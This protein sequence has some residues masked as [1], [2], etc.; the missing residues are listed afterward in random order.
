MFEIIII[1]INNTKK[2]KVMMVLMYFFPDRKISE[3]V[4]TTRKEHRVTWAFLNLYISYEDRNL[5][6]SIYISILFCHLLFS[7][8]FLVKGNIKYTIS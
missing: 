7:Y 8:S 2:K 6:G 5:L 3:N 4:R 1:I